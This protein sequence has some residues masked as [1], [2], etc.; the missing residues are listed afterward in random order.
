MKT[1][2]QALFLNNLFFNGSLIVLSGS[3]VANLGAYLYHLALGRLLGPADYSILQSLISILY[4]LGLPMMVFN[5][6]IVKYI[7]GERSSE[8][9]GQFVTKFFNKAFYWGLLAFIF[10]LLLFPL[11][12]NFLRIESF[13][14]FF[15]LGLSA[16][17]GVFVALFSS[18]LQGIMKFKELAVF[19]IF[20]SWLKLFISVLLVYL[21]FR[22]GGAVM[23]LVLS[24]L[25][26]G[27]FGLGRIKKYIAIF[28]QG[29][30]VPKNYFGN[31]GKYSI[32]VLFTNLS[33]ISFFTVDIILARHFLPPVQAGYY[34]A[35]SVLG[36]II[37][38]A[39]S[40]I[41]SVMF[42]LVSQKHQK[43]ESCQKIFWLSFLLILLISLGI[44]VIYFYLPELMVNL[45]FGPAYLGAASSLWLFAIFLTL[46]AIC[47]LFLN[48]YLSIF[49]TKAIF[50]SVLFAIVQVVLIYFNRGSVEEIVKANILTLSLLLIGLLLFYLKNIRFKLS[51]L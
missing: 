4:Y 7:S 14:L 25:L 41:I 38:F 30:A 45:L 19:N 13:W 31:M 17:L 34:A 18:S 1:K 20:S 28:K 27:A 3:V 36:K 29:V 42:P 22:V 21:G 35:L 12:R 33:L 5:V 11:F 15:G 46:Y 43:G 37:F 24:S 32:A 49:Q 2:L 6:V 8:K 39:S 10:F 44:G 40:P 26:V 23:G 50:L 48:F 16:Y 9:I 51:Q 47:S